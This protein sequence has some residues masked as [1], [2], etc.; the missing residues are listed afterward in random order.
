MKQNTVKSEH[1]FENSV[2]KPGPATI[3]P[4]DL[5]RVQTLDLVALGVGPSSSAP[6]DALH[7]QGA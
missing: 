3:L 5:V 4:A 2:N 6:L 7:W 1:F